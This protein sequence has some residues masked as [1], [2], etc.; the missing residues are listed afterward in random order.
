MD[1]NEKDK[2]RRGFL[3]D[4][5][6]LTALPFLP[7]G[8]LQGTGQPSNIK[9]VE[10]TTHELSDGEVFAGTFAVNGAEVRARI[11]RVDSG[12]TYTL[13]S[14]IV[15]GQKT[16]MQVINGT[17]AK[18]EPDGDRRLDTL[19]VTRFEPDGT[20]VQLEP[21]QVSVVTSHPYAGL[22][23]EETLK[24]FMADKAAGRWE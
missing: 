6:L 17:K 20:A 5:A 10:W 23:P 21:R 19:R 11:L 9:I 24:A 18:G 8:L 1:E 4:A 3:K 7:L 14:H 15:I 2:G 16:H 12:P 13:F 22:S